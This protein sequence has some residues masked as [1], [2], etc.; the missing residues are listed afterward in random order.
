MRTAVRALCALSLVLAPLPLG[1][2]QGD[3]FVLPPGTLRLGVTAEL[4]R[5]DALFAEDGTR[6]LGSELTGPLTAQSF[7]PL[8]GPQSEL[9]RFLAA[10]GSPLGVDAQSF[11]LGSLELEAVATPR[12]VPLSLSAGVLPRLEVGVSVPLIREEILFTRFGLDGGTL[13]PNPDPD[14]NAE[15]LARFGEEWGALGSARLLPVDSSALGRELQ[16]LVEARFPGEAL[17]LPA[18]T[19]DAAVLNELLASGLGLAPLEARVGE[20]RTGDVEVTARFLVLSTFGVA[21][22]PADSGGIHYRA[23]VSLSGRL[24]TGAE[25]DTTRLLSFPPDAGMGGFGA[26]VDGDLFVGHRLWTTASVRYARR[27]GVEVLRR[28]AAPEA[29]LASEARPETVRWSPADVLSLRVAPRYRLTEAISLGAQYS[30]ARLGDTSFEAPGAPGEASLLD[31]AGGLAQGVGAGVR[32]STLPA[33]ARGARLL[34]V[35]VLLSYETTLDA[36]AGHPDASALVL[37]AS[38]LIGNRQ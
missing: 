16:R 8:R 17:A 31:T 29:P 15:L 33:R 32:Y 35:E 22:V 21:A 7:A 38:V 14:A 13:G 28:V 5:F 36:P 27:S 10:A 9:G 23:A 4:G 26:G 12:V 11:T 3:A 24:P 20:W 2:Q 6:A 34:P 25:G 30:L 19:A 18:D 1:A 37:Q